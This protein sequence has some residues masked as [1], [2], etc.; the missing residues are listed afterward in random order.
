[1][2]NNYKSKN[3]L[4][5]ETNRLIGSLTY[6]LFH[7]FIFYISFKIWG[8]Q[9]VEEIWFYVMHVVAYMLVGV[10]LRWTRIWVY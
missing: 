5:P 9:M 4:D 8:M 2:G 7:S 3:G 1:M 6:F 10:F